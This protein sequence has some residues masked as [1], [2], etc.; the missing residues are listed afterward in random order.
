MAAAALCLMISLMVSFA[1]SMEG[2][3]KLEDLKKQLQTIE[4]IIEFGKANLESERRK[5]FEVMAGNTARAKC[6]KSIP[7]LPLPTVKHMVD[8][9]EK[10][11]AHVKRSF[12]DMA[13]VVQDLES[14]LEDMK[15]RLKYFEHNEL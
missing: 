12:A 8:Y 2:N 7:D 6:L 4:Q 14:Q 15:A 13:A 5:I 3:I 10:T 9:T 1:S 11:N